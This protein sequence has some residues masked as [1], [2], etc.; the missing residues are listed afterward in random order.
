MGSVLVIAWILPF[1]DVTSHSMTGRCSLED[2]LT[3]GPII[4]DAVFHPVSRFQHFGL[5]RRGRG[6]LPEGF[7]AAEILASNLE[8]TWLS[9][10]IQETTATILTTALTSKKAR[11]G[12][13]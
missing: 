5:F 1:P 9:L 10:H 13:L 3:C 2:D 11:V 6:A 8:K 4:D 12:Q 7:V